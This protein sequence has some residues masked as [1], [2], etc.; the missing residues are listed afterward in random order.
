MC[1]FR[2]SFFLGYNY[3]LID[4]KIL[5]KN[6]YTGKMSEQQP[7]GDKDVPIFAS[8]TGEYQNLDLI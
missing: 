3:E 1:N 5:I 4:G 2:T 8:A 6:Q 7:F